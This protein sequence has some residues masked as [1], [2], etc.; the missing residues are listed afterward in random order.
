MEIR[1]ATHHDDD[2]FVRH[3]LA[4]WATEDWPAKQYHPDAAARV[5][6]Y[7]AEAR[8]RGDL[9]GFVAVDSEE[10]VGALA[11]LLHY[12]PYPVVIKPAYL[13]LAYVWSLYVAPA[14]RGQKIA[15]PLL[16]HAADH[17]RKLGCSSIVLHTV[18]DAHAFYARMG[19]KPATEL[20]MTL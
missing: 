3:Y 14:R 7:M 5:L 18:L 11:C 20:R 12:A 17:L 4:E 2:M 1:P 15:Q 9:G 16:E 13:H 10:V 6:Q 8:A 19:F